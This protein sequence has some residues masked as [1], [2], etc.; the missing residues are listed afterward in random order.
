MA[1]ILPK[2]LFGEKYVD[3]VIA[4]ATR[5]PSSLQS[6]SVIHAGPL[7]DRGRAAD[8]LRQADPGAA[9][10]STRRAVGR[11]VEHR[12]ALQGR[13]EELGQ[14]LVL[15]DTYFAGLNQ[16]LPNIQHDISGLADLAEQLRQAAPDLLDILATSR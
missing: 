13:G 8:V 6:G 1:R 12:E 11:A 2:T 5:R 15:I 10:R 16:D 3:L 9:T 7:A 4:G 14:N